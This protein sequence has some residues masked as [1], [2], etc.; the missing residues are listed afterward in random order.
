MDIFWDDEFTEAQDEAVVNYIDDVH[1]EDTTSSDEDFYNQASEPMY[2]ERNLAK[3]N[4]E[5]WE[6]VSSEMYTER[7]QKGR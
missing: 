2:L 7:R 5:Q 1:F 4:S 3:V 6:L